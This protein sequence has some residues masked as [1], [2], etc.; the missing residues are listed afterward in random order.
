MIG[1]E[2]RVEMEGKLLFSKPLDKIELSDIVAF[3]QEWAE[4]VRVEYKRQT[5][6]TIPKIVSSFANTSGRILIT[7]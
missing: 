2:H 5:P 7:H 6:N 4:G 1:G 3:C